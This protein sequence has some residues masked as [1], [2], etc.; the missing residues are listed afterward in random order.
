[1]SSDLVSN[2]ASGLYSTFSFS[3]IIFVSSTLLTISSVAALTRTTG[4]SLASLTTRSSLAGFVSLR[5]FLGFRAG[6]AVGA[7]WADFI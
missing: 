3:V 1:M 5:L 2:L 7:G 4:G 6:G